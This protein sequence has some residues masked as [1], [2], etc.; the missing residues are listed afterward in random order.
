MPTR[1]ELKVE[2]YFWIVTLRSTV[3][4]DS[5]IVSS[6]TNKGFLAGALIIIGRRL[7]WVIL[8]TVVM[9]VAERL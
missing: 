7:D 3:R 8:N 6:M 5:W 4:V 9:K 2:H 1:K